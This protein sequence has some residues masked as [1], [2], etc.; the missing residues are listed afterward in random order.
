MTQPTFEKNLAAIL[1]ADVAEYCRLTD[2]N[3]DD[4]HVLLCEYFDTIDRIV[5]ANTGT[6]ENYAGDAVLATFPSAAS[7]LLCAE[8]IQAEI[9]KRNAESPPDRRLQFRIGI[10]IG[11][12]FRSR[13]DVYGNGV[14]IAARLEALAEPGGVCISEAVHDAIGKNLP[15]SY[16]FLGEKR[17]KNLSR[18]IRVYRV[19]FAEQP[20]RPKLRRTGLRWISI[21]ATATIII[22]VAAW[23]GLRIPPDVEPAPLSS[24]G[25]DVGE[26]MSYED[27]RKLFP[28]TEKGTYKYNGEWVW[29]AEYYSIGNRAG[30]HNPLSGMSGSLNSDEATDIY[31]GEWTQPVA[32]DGNA[33]FCSSYFPD[34]SMDCFK[35]RSVNFPE[36]SNPASVPLFLRFDKNGGC[37]GVSYFEKGDTTSKPQPE[38]L[39]FLLKVSGSCLGPKGQ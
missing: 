39:M 2:E 20:G 8:T 37:D 32:T 12:I 27:L 38:N 11:D 22:A 24:L 4:T 29:F 7:A 9:K 14:N 15:I 5:K 36:Q 23:L 3:E 35:Y 16:K 28:V 25:L 33:V 18:P 6:I 30:N 21:A 19:D 26:F 31:E 1:H 34:R 17:V 10:N 13:D